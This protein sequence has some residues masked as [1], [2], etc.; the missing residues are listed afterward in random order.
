VSRI[1]AFLL[2]AMALACVVSAALIVLASRSSG[3]G[4]FEASADPSP[5]PE[6]TVEPPDARVREAGNVCEGT[7]R[8]PDPGQPHIFAEIYTK[9]REVGGFYIVGDED[10]DDEAF[11]EAV[12]TVERVFAHNDLEQRLV[13]EGAYV[14]IADA[15]QEVLDLP[16]FG[17]LQGQVSQDFFSRVCGIADRADYPVATVN[18]LDLLGNRHGPCGGLNV[19]YHE[20]GHLVQGWTLDPADWFDVKLYYQQ[21]LDAGK[22]LKQYAAG[23]PNGGKDRSW[24][25]RYDPDLYQ[26]LDR[27]YNDN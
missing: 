19:L 2:P 1:F 22:Y 21:A 18:E 8:R 25:E 20:L 13:E 9:Q 17:C 24:L 27:I 26:M 23:E 10:V 6:A 7:M 12:R 11:D 15:G 4:S 16:E 3:P 5:T 14:I